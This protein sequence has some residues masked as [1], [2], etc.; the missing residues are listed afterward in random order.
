MKRPLALSV[1]VSQCSETPAWGTSEPWAQHLL[2]QELLLMWECF[3][4]EGRRK[5]KSPQIG[6]AEQGWGRLHWCLWGLM[7]RGLA[8]GWAGS[9]EG[10]SNPKHDSGWKDELNLKFS[11]VWALLLIWLGISFC[12][13]HLKK[14]QK[15][16]KSTRAGQRVS[17]KHKLLSKVWKIRMKCFCFLSVL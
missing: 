13:A 3:Q 8:E 10:S 2:P 12:F 11:V 14:N 9:P 4:W 6:H 1:K 16:Q 7:E 17:L 15:K 5:K